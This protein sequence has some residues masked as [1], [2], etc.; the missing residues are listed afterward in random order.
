MVTKLKIRG[1]QLFLDLVWIKSVKI[2]LSRRL[3]GFVRG[4]VGEFM[5]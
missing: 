2:L 1:N 5:G 3:D 4:K